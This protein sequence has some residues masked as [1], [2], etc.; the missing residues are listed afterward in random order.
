VIDRL[1]AAVWIVKN[2]QGRRNVTQDELRYIC[3][4]VYQSEKKARGRPGA[5]HGEGKSVQNEHFSKTGKTEERVGSEFGFSPATV[6]RNEKFAEQ[7]DA[8]A[9]KHGPEAK[10]EILA[11]RK[12]VEDYILPEPKTVKIP[13]SDPEP[14]IDEEASA[15]PA[16]EPETSSAA[17]SV[18]EQPSASALPEGDPLRGWSKQSESDH[19][20]WLIKNV[21]ANGDHGLRSGAVDITDTGSENLVDPEKAERFANS[22][23]NHLCQIEHHAIMLPS[24]IKREAPDAE[25]REML[26]TKLARLVDALQTIVA[27]L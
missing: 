19:V 18:G 21:P 23:M 14:P 4:K 25:R 9:A 10:A 13:K 8:I 11:R 7:V 6:R 20:Q 22:Y 26:K 27:S 2:Q 17:P 15:A 5:D 3:G 24:A 1:G 12:K 16:S